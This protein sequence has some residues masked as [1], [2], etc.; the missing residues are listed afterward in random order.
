[1]DI[2]KR[3][4]FFTKHNGEKAPLPFSDTEYKNRLAKL[5]EI[6]AITDEV[7]VINDD[8]KGGTRQVVGV[9]DGCFCLSRFAICAGQALEKHPLGSS[10]GRETS[11]IV[12][13]CSGVLQSR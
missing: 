12:Q 2:N 3:P 10:I 1:M 13:V 11:V 8:V 9:E 6:M 7:S 4:L 5:R